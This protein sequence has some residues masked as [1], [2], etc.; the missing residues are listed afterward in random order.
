MEWQIFALVVTA[1]GGEI[2]PAVAQEI[3]RRPLFGDPDRMMQRQHGDG[4]RQP[5]ARAACRDR[6]EHEIGAGEHAERVEM[7][8]ADPGRMHA[9]R[10]AVERLGRDVGDELIRRARVIVVVVVAQREIAEV[11]QSLPDLR[12][13]LAISSAAAQGTCH[14]QSNGRFR[15]FRAYLLRTAGNA[16]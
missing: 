3:E 10:L 2:D 8:L 11:H 16:D 6:R 15:S 12:V 13:R 14:T 5:D 4:R 1:P 9:D 7:V